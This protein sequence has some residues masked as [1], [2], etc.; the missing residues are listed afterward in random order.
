VTRASPLVA[1][2]RRPGGPVPLRI[3]LTAD[4]D[5]AGNPVAAAALVAER[6][7]LRVVEAGDRDQAV[8]EVRRA[9]QSLGAVRITPESVAAL[10][11]VLVRTTLDEPVPSGVARFDGAEPEPPFRPTAAHPRA[12]E[13]TGAR[14]PKRPA[15]R[16]FDLQAVA[17]DPRASRALVEQFPREVAAAQALLAEVDRERAVLALGDE[18]AGWD[19]TGLPAPFR[20]MVWPRLRWA[21][22][23]PA[24]RVLADVRRHGPDAVPGLLAATG[25]WLARESTER[26]LPWLHGALAL[27]GDMAE[28]ALFVC[29]EAG[30]GELPVAGVPLVELVAANAG[31]RQGFAYELRTL[32]EAQGR[33]VEPRLLLPGL[34]LLRGAGRRV[35][36]GDQ[37]AVELVP[38]E[39]LRE[40]GRAH[41]WEGW[42]Q[43]EGDLWETLSASHGLAAAVLAQP[44]GSVAGGAAEEL[45]RAI[46][47]GWFD[48]DPGDLA[49]WWIESLP[50][51]VDLVR[52]RP[53][54]YAVKAADTLAEAVYTYKRL[55]VLRELWPWITPLAARLAAPPFRTDARSF[56]VWNN[57]V[58]HPPHDA[59]RAAMAAPDRLWRELERRCRVPTQAAVLSCG[60]DAL[61]RAHGAR[62]AGAFLTGSP[63][64]YEVAGLVGGM[65]DTSANRVCRLGDDV[66]DPIAWLGRIRDG[67]LADLSRGLNADVSRPGVRHALMLQRTVTDNRRA[68]R[69]FLRAH[70]DGDAEYVGRHP[71]TLRWL[72]AHPAVDAARWARGISLEATVAGIGA[73][74]LRVETDPLEALRLGT[75][76]GS[77][78]S[79]RG[80]CDYSAVAVALDVNKQ[81]VYAR[82]RRGSVIARQLLALSEDDAVVA[83]AVYPLSA[84]AAVRRLF[85]RYDRAFAAQ[86][87]LP[88]RRGAVGDDGYTIAEVISSDWWDDGAWESA[89]VPSNSGATRR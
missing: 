45:L 63:I 75:Y 65:S 22:V 5:W 51:M 64:L 44:W 60:F 17:L 36:L 9:W 40:L 58:E 21:P 32:L 73:L 62:L 26:V 72:A 23:Q 54:E 74:T 8:V 70:M 79:V 56:L 82:N 87:G 55:D 48:G 67:A 76:V 19:G 1:I 37:R 43:L 85:A 11:L 42:Q 41:A 78:L 6:I 83:F 61:G 35:W 3:E 16:R 28:V 47:Y 7:P 59:R 2:V 88:L 81:V 33:G 25:W 68:L 38:A 27:P 39:A 18:A 52:G 80:A 29:A 24:A 10:L 46:A 13:G 31:D 50:G 77:C 30:A 71:L 14:P 20:R 69:K 86:L 84:P 89:F 53:P 34:E 15:P 57:L 12:Y 66:A 4:L 49:A